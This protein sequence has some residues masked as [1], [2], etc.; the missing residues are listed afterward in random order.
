MNI[1]CFFGHKYDK[2]EYIGP[3]GRYYSKL[4]RVCKKCGKIDIYIGLIE[5]DILTGSKIPLLKINY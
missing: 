2:W 1:K 3:S 5:E 4:K